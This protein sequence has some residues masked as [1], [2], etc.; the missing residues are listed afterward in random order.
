MPIPQQTSVWPWVETS[1]D[2]LDL[3]AS[4]DQLVIAE[5]VLSAQIACNM[6]RR[7]L[8]CMGGRLFGQLL[9]VDCDQCGIEQRY[10]ISYPIVFVA[11]NVQ[12][13]RCGIGGIL[14]I[15]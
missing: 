10:I 11:V 6:P 14:C 2:T 12:C 5:T 15:F 3:C 9:S 8:K 7:S 1:A 4:A 13:F